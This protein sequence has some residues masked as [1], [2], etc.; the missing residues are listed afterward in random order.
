LNQVLQKNFGLAEKTFAMRQIYMTT[1][2][3]EERE[4]VRKDE[5]RKYYQEYLKKLI[6]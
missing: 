6:F 2:M 1:K 4:R 3:D 5:I